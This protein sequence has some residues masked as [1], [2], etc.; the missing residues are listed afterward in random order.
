MRGESSGARI[1]SGAA[2][3]WCGSRVTRG[4]IMRA[5][6]RGLSSEFGE[7]LPPRKR[8][9]REGHLCKPEEHEQCA[10]FSAAMV[11][12]QGTVRSTA[13]ISMPGPRRTLGKLPPRICTARACCLPGGGSPP[14][15]KG[16]L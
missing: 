7:V 1:T 12:Y 2:C 15:L 3:S 6:D 4:P 16:T 10:Q 9:L 13:R 8:W 11:G 5:V 14:I